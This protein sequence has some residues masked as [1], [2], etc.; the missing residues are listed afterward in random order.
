[1]NWAAFEF[2]SFVAGV[3]GLAVAARRGPNWLERRRARRAL[4]AASLLD[5]TSVEGASVHVTGLV[6][7]L[8]RTV[9]AP[10]SASTCVVAR[11]RVRVGGSFGDFSAP[12]ETMAFAPFVVVLDDQRWVLVDGNYAQLD[13]AARRSR[14]DEAR[15]TEL[16]AE[17]YVGQ[18]QSTL[19]RFEEVVVVPGDRVSVA[20]LLMKDAGTAPTMEERGF[21]DSVAPTV[22][23][24]GNL[25]NPI[26]IGTPVD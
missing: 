26:V 6:R 5:G 24:V 20:G 12:Y 16:L 10:L 2:V 7:V 14:F 1:M 4:S 21:R 22:R 25:A 11:A 23:L 17:H 15:R 9:T 18:R 19:A 8:D 13:L 3:V